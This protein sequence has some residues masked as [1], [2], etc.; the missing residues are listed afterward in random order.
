[1]FKTSFSP[2]AV[3]NFKHLDYGSG[4]GVMS[5]ILRDSGWN[6]IAYDPYSSPVRPAGKFNF[7]TAIEVVEHSAN[8]IATIEDM[9]S[10]LT[11]DG[12]IMFSTLLAD[13]DTKL[14]WW[15][16]GA[17]NGHI[18]IL[19]DASLKII[20]K[21]TG[22]FFSSMRPNLHLLQSNRSNYAALERGRK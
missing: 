1:M 21:R 5:G 19:S 2:L 13:K 3:K 14:D 16:I 4:A 17:R 18:G 9:K 7:I 6:S 15:Y 20:G 22:M 10:F 12:V 8:I 11:N